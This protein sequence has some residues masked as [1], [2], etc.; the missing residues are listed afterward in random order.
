[1]FS[2]V[3]IYFFLLRSPYPLTDFRC[4]SSHLKWARADTKGL[5][6]PRY[7][8]ISTAYHDFVETHED[9]SIRKPNLVLALNCGFIFYKEW[10][11]TLPSLTKYPNIPLVFTEY[12]HEDC[13]YDFNKL[14]MHSDRQIFFA[15]IC[16]DFSTRYI[17]S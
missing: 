3:F 4:I 1:M 16:L 14:G 8:F 9:N 17:S 2:H 7:V 15:I 10:D 5:Q 6:I 13:K 11:A 12:Y